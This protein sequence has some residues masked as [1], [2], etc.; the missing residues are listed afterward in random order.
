MT[1][2]RREPELQIAGR[3][4]NLPVTPINELTNKAVLG[5]GS[6]IGTG[7]VTVLGLLMWYGVR[8]YIDSI[9]VQK[10][11]YMQDKF[12]MKRDVIDMQLRWAN[13][14]AYEIN[15]VFMVAGSELD[16]ASSRRLG[17]D[18]AYY[19]NL[20]ADLLRERADLAR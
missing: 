13:Q 3:D 10:E 15:E 12:V 11:N 9:Y 4:I 8:Y 5:L 14:R 20:K 1:S 2:T 19:E 17:A 6:L 7:L 16:G 18:K